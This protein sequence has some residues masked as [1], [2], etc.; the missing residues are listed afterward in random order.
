MHFN[1]GYSPVWSHKYFLFSYTMGCVMKKKINKIRWRLFF[2]DSS[3]KLKMNVKEVNF[4]RWMAFNHIDSRIWNIYEIWVYEFN[5][6]SSYITYTLRIHLNIISWKFSLLV[7]H[8]PAESLL[9]WQWLR[10]LNYWKIEWT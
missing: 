3:N 10:N 2:L 5:S 6:S 8:V 1:M 4:L 9:E 7:V